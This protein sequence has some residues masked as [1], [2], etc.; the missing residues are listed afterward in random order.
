MEWD[1]AFREYLKKLDEHKPIIYCGDLNV[2]HN[3][4]GGWWY[5]QSSVH[6]LHAVLQLQAIV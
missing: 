6:S 5:V 2:A 3:P 1:K 4:I